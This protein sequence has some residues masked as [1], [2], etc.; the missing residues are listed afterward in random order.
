MRE[1]RVLFVMHCKNPDRRE[2]LYQVISEMKIPLGYE[3]VAIEIPYSEKGIAGEYN[4]I[5]KEDDAKYKFYLSDNVERVDY[6]MAMR[7]I[8][9]FRKDSK[10]GMIGLFGSELPLD[11]DFTKARKR[12]GS[13]EFQNDGKVMAYAAENPIF[14]QRVHVLDDGLVATCRDIAWDEAVEPHF[15]MAAQCCRFRRT[16]FEIYVPM[17]NTPWLLHH[18]NRC[19]YGEPVEPAR[20]AAR[21]HFLATYLDIIQPKV[22]IL[23]PAYNQPGFFLEAFEVVN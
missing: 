16:G 7:V 9:F 1:N 8:D 18:E 4:R 17:Q 12:Y 5:I 20:N 14:R 6:Q 23:I 21:K 15:L 13:Y 2:H 11:G 3:G 19:L 10:V 22:S